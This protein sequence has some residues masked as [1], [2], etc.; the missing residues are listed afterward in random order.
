MRDASFSVIQ[1]PNTVT[2][3]VDGPNCVWFDTELEVFSWAFSCDKL[4][5]KR[6]EYRHSCWE[7]RYCT[8]F[9]TGWQWTNKNQNVYFGCLFRV[10]IEVGALREYATDG[11]MTLGRYVLGTAGNDDIGISIHPWSK[12]TNK[13]KKRIPC[14]S[15]IGLLKELNQ[16]SYVLSKLF[17]EHQY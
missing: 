8:A 3:T 12:Q 11:G 1:K 17:G 14:V 15:R 13:N 16:I 2:I 6:Q 7:Y 5:L 10:G 9:W 4:P